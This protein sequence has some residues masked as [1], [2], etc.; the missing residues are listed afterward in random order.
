[1]K[2]G[3]ANAAQAGD[4]EAGALHI[5]GREFLLARTLTERGQ[6][7]GQLPDAFAVHVA[8]H[9]NHQPLGRV[10]RNAEMVVALAHQVFA[11]GVERA[12]KLGCSFRVAA[13][14]FMK[15]A[16]RVRRTPRCLPAR[17]RPCEML[18]GR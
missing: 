10:H 6:L 5:G 1:V 7:A 8:H 9:G 16:S 2:T 18:P 4:G 3:A 13:V 15:K 11:G 12:L 14:A 17:P